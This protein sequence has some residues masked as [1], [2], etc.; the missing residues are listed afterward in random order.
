MESQK[1]I[2]NLQKAGI[3]PAYKAKQ[4]IKTRESWGIKEGPDGRSFNLYSSS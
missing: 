2:S 1:S 4:T 3:K